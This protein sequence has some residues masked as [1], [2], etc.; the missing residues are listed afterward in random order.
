MCR[1]D[2][3]T[4]L[5]VV[6][7]ESVELRC[8]LHSLFDSTC[9]CSCTE[10]CDSSTHLPFIICS[11]WSCGVKILTACSTCSCSSSTSSVGITR[12]SIDIQS[13]KSCAILTATKIWVASWKTCM[14]E[15]LMP[16]T[17]IDPKFKASFPNALG[18]MGGVYLIWRH[19]YY[20]RAANKWGI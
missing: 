1:C 9:S 12:S 18:N 7:F 6:E 13:W 17:R 10:S 4:R 8:Q 15:T 20:S 11:V 14:P 19:C 2:P 3:T 16:E 5:Q